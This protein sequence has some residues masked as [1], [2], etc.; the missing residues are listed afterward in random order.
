M[1]QKDCDA[2]REAG[3]VG[4]VVGLVG[5]GLTFDSGGYVTFPLTPIFV[6]YKSQSL[7]YILLWP[8]P[9]CLTVITRQKS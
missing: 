1:I 8:P 2:R 7:D 4:K 6:F 9:R 5:K 3:K